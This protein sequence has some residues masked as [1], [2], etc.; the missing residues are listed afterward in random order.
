MTNEQLVARIQAGEDE[1]ENMLKLWQQTQGFIAKMAIRYQAYAE[2]DDLKQEGYFGLCEAVRYYQVCREA[3]FI[4]YAAFWIR[5]AMQRYVDNCSGNIRIPV[6]A[7]EWL[8][9][10][11]KTMEEYRKY[12]GDWPPESALCT[13]L[14][15][16]LEKLHTI[17][18]NAEMR[19]IQSLSEPIAGED[20]RTIGDTVPGD[21]DMESNIIDCLDK[22]A[23]KRELWIAVDQLPENLPSVIR[24]RYLYGMTLKEVGQSMGID[25]EKVRQIEAKAI[26]I[27][28]MPGKCKRFR[29]YYEEYLAVA[30]IHHVG[31]KTFRCTWMS[32]VE[33][34]VLCYN[35]RLFGTVSNT[36]V[37]KNADKPLKSVLLN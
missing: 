15:I 35:P 7:R 34:E 9:K 17:Q 24:H 27:L 18:K 37:T 29:G 14:G 13:L 8:R 32:E 30:P 16:S 23:M 33:K 5:Q 1:A 2:L 26:R 20:D 28:R 19:Q 12:Y 21:E 22:E 3:S 31:L 6:S 4:H 11:D 10:Y 36:L 25:I